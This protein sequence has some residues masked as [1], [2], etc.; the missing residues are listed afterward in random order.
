MSAPLT[1]L[2]PLQV[3]IDP[4]RPGRI[5]IICKLGRTRRNSSVFRIFPPVL[6]IGWN[7]D[8]NQQSAPCVWRYGAGAP[9]I[10]GLTAAGADLSSNSCYLTQREIV[11]SKPLSVRRPAC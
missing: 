9:M 1:Y 3:S 11:G 2:V 8:N 10:A 6:W 4:E 5:A 7:G